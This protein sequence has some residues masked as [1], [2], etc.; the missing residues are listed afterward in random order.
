MTFDEL[1]NADY[2]FPTVAMFYSFACAPC[3]RLKPRL[4]DVCK[5]MGVRLEEFNSASEL[6]TIKDLGIRSVPAVVVV[7]RGGIVK[8]AFVGSQDNIRELLLAAGIQ[9]H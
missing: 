3:E 5:L 2:R 4:R 8:T 6:P 9:E 7:H 1:R